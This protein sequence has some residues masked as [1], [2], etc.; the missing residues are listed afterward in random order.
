MTTGRLAVIALLILLILTY[1]AL[2]YK[3]GYNAGFT[4]ATMYE[5]STE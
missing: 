4:Q 2:K 3:Q 5:G 1:G